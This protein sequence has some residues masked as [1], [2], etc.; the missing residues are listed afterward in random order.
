MCIKL[1]LLHWLYLVMLHL[2]IIP[3][4]IFTKHCQNYSMAHSNHHKL[5][6]TTLHCIFINYFDY[7][8]NCIALFSHE[9]Q[10]QNLFAVAILN[11]I[12]KYIPFGYSNTICD[13]NMANSLSLVTLSSLSVVLIKYILIIHHKHIHYIIFQ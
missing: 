6:S 13:R 10:C 11:V 2:W 7:I 8:T 1:I 3:N 5:N 9:K 12:I 4:M